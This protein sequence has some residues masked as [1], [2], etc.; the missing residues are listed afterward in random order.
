MAVR[1]LRARVRGA[2]YS[3]SPREGERDDY[4]FSPREGERAGYS[5]SPREGE[6]DGCSFSLCEGSCSFSDG[7]RVLGDP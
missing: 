2:D 5:L 6:R 1:S 7:V 4:S 3:F